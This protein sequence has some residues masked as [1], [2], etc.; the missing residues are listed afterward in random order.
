AVGAR[1]MAAGAKL[2]LG[3]LSAKDVEVR[4][5]AVE[6]LAEIG[7]KEAGE[8]IQKLLADGEAR[9]RTAAALAAGKLALRPAAGRL[10][11]LAGDG[12]GGV[13]R[14]SLAALRQLGEPRAL[15]VA[16][17]ALGDEDVAAEALECVAVL[18][19]P[20]NA[21]A[22][23]ELARKRPSAEILAGVGKAL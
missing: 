22:V 2:L 21:A 11:G 9:V 5:C 20:A 16:V 7:P 3:K 23:A 6:A 17:A 10:L 8:P 1:K 15:P 12:D 14:A 18:G 4:A 13:R 19:G